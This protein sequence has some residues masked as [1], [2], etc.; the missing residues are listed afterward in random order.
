MD[1]S[2]PNALLASLKNV[3]GYNEASFLSAHKESIPVTSVRYNPLK[4]PLVSGLELPSEKVE[5]C[6][7]A[8]YLAERPSFTYDPLFHAG[9]Y[10]V[11]EASSMFVWHA[12]AQ[13]FSNDAKIK[14]LDLCAAPGGKSTLLTSYFNNGLVVSNEVVKTRA[15]ILVE[16]TTKWGSGNIVVSNNDPKQFS[17][18]EGYFDLLLIDAPCSGSGLFRKDEDAIDEWSEDN[19]AL[20]SARQKRILADALPALKENGILIYSTCSYS[21]EENEQIGEW[22]S[23]QFGLESVRLPLEE[24]W[25]IVETE[26]PKGFGYRFYP[27]KVHGEGF[28]LSVFRKKEAGYFTGYAKQK[29][30][31]PSKQETAVIT[32]WLETEQ[33]IFFKQNEAI[34]AIQN[35]WEHDIPILQQYLYLRKAGTTIG[36]VKGKDL[37]P[38]HDLAVSILPIS[39][40]AQKVALDKTNALQYLKRKEVEIE[41]AQT[42]WALLT[43]NEL[44]LGWAKILPNRM[45]NYY[46]MEWRILKD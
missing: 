17:H 46:P 31:A 1:K 29:L 30:N 7:Y 24:E 32:E 13:C 19:V 40:K 20:C 38:A 4:L 9:A 39:S 8:Y 34:L 43:Y 16:N 33:H 11:Q 45:N 14:A 10:Y 6:P 36:T 35:D 21:A 26:F 41:N 5:W 22:L 28:Y 37:I 25:G 2:L 12:L 42:G 3:K 44:N 15:S 23:Q 18:L 27:D